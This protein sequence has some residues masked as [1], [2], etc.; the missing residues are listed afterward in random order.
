[1]PVGHSWQL[2]SD[3]APSLSAT[4]P[5]GH[6]MHDVSHVPSEPLYLPFPHNV[7]DPAESVCLFPSVPIPPPQLIRTLPGWQGEQTSQCEADDLPVRVLYLPTSQSKHSDLPSESWNCP[8]G[9]SWQDKCLT[10][11]AAASSLNEPSGQRK[12]LSEPKPE[13]FP[14]PQVVQSLAVSCLMGSLPASAKNLPASHDT[15]EFLLDMEEDR[16]CPLSQTLQYA[17]PCWLLYSP[18]RQ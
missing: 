1:L 6:C 12:Q 14:N 16:Y 8:F 7:H 3:A 5:S 11:F 10:G 13:Y 15:H 18:L 4:R 2:V 17:R 9:Q